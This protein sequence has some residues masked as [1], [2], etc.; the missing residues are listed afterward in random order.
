MNPQPPSRSR[1]FQPERWGLSPAVR[2]WIFV[3]LLAGLFVYAVVGADEARACGTLTLALV[4]LGIYLLRRAQL[5]DDRSQPIYD[6]ES[7]YLP[8]PTDT[9]LEAAVTGALLHG[10]SDDGDAN[11]EEDAPDFD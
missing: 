5:S 6:E 7:D 2:L 9:A 10:R 11:E 1:I 8:S 3:L 4:A